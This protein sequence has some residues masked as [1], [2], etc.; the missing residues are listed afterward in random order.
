M[1]QGIELFEGSIKDNIARFRDTAPGQVVEAAKLAG[2]HDLILSLPKGYDSVLG[3]DGIV[4]SGGQRQRIAL[5]RAIYGNPCL[6]VLDEP[7]SNL[8]GEGEMALRNV[9]A[10]LKARGASVLMVAHRPAILLCLDKLLVMTEGRIA[11]FGGTQ[12]IMPQIAPGF[13]A[14]PR[15]IA[16]TA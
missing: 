4:M 3:P 15:P 14:P 9:I 12:Q 11:G 13:A 6:V 5:A 1:P 16:V 7:T 8:D 2:I 10:Q